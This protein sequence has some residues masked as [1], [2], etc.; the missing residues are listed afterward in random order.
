MGDHQQVD[1]G[2]GPAGESARAN[3]RG[4]RFVGCCTVLI[5][6]RRLCTHGTVPSESA[7]QAAGRQ[8]DE[9]F[10]CLQPNKYSPLRKWWDPTLLF[11][12]VSIMTINPDTGELLLHADYSTGVCTGNISKFLALSR[13]WP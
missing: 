13:L 1:D 10:S 9:L 3:V 7:M 2:D 12:G 5:L 6:Q 4:R 8:A 11:T